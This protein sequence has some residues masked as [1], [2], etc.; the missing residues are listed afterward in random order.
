M[1]GVRGGSKGYHSI[2]DW[3]TPFGTPLTTATSNIGS[4]Q[5]LSKIAPNWSERG[6]RQLMVR[7]RGLITTPLSQRDCPPSRWEKGQAESILAH[8]SLRS[9][10]HNQDDDNRCDEC[11]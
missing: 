2:S 9:A 6:Q 10:K 1:A 11:I 3:S 5:H 8:V 7:G 4:A